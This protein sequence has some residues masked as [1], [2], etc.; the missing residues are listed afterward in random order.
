MP[1]AR[2][3]LTAIIPNRN[4]SALLP[5]SLGALR[6]QSRQPD[7]IIVIDDASSDNSRDVV[8]EFM[9]SMPQLRLLENPVR[10]GVERSLN[11]G[12]QEATG[13]AVYCGAADDATDP[14]FFEVVLDALE[15]H[16]EAALA[17]SEARVLTE[18][19]TP[20]GLRP[21]SMPAFRETYLSPAD[22]ANMLRRMDNCMLSVVAIWRRDRILA[23][24]GFD[25]ALGSFAD[26]F[27]QR[28]IALES[29][30][31]FVPKVLGTWFV[32][33]ESYSRSSSVNA[34]LM[35]RLIGACCDRM[36][37]AEGVVFPAGYSEVF[38]RRAR[39]ACARIAT[40]AP[41]YDPGLINAL[42]HGGSAEK[43]FLTL[44]GWLPDALR[45]LAALGWLTLRLRPTSL[46]RLQQ[47]AAY[48]LRRK[49]QGLVA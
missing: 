31:V 7:E 5:R 19:G 27:L 40:M 6:R 14:E 10:L 46:V 20:L 29:G 3:H 11:R 21:I 47:S 33:P 44:A 30:F 4:H 22:T 42:A 2:L 9:A 49:W 32:Q 12:V 34:D 45:R 38:V 18:N 26:S 37:T 28:R 35:D 1:S 36:K 43:R 24:G 39:F 23:A 8:R 17:C 15:R 41:S 25:P 16:P 48:R 13:D